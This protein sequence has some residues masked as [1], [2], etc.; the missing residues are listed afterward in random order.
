MISNTPSDCNYKLDGLTEGRT[1]GW[2]ER[3]EDE[4]LYQLIDS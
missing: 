3:T 1:E 4:L 2:I